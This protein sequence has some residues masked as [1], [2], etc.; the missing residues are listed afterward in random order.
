MDTYLSSKKIETYNP[1][2]YSNMLAT[3][4]LLTTLFLAFSWKT[5]TAEHAYTSNEVAGHSEKILINTEEAIALLRIEP[6]SSLAKVN[7]SLKLIEKIEESFKQHVKTEVG[8]STTTHTH[9]LPKL[10]LVA[11]Y[12]TRTLPTLQ[13]KLYSDGTLYFGSTGKPIPE[14]AAYFD[15][16]YAKASLL[17]AKDAIN[18]NHSLEAMANLRRVFESV[19]LEPEFLVSDSVM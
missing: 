1:K 10:D 17:T 19:Y 4:T 5:A 6:K 15:Y 18:S 13:Y 2:S 12:E 14:K 8:D 16:S 3:L 7:D 11:V 9:Y